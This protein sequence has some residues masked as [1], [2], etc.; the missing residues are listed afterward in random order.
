MERLRLLRVDTEHE[1]PRLVNHKERD[2]RLEQE[3]VSV[4]EQLKHAEEGVAK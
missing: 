4:R 3:L 1:V 2:E